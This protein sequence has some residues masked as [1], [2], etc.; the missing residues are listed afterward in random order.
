MSD[1]FEAFLR[2]SAV[3][4]ICFGLLLVVWMQITFYKSEWEWW[5]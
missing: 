5:P 1:T 2:Q 3:I 4:G